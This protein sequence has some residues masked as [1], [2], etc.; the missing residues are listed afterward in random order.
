[1]CLPTGLDALPDILEGPDVAPFLLARASN[2]LEPLME[3]RSR[4][5]HK[6]WA[7]CSEVIGMHQFKSC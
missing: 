1:M 3:L 2:L 7:A 5:C 6:S 4:V